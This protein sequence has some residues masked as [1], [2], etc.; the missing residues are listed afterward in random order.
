MMKKR[1]KFTHFLMAK[2]PFRRVTDNTHK[3]ASSK[4]NDVKLMALY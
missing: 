4:M 2:G 1:D 3:A